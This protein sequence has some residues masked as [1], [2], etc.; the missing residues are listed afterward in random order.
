MI[1]LIKCYLHLSNPPLT[2]FNK[3]ILK[4]NEIVLQTILGGG[5][6]GTLTLF[7]EKESRKIQIFYG[8]LLLE[9]FQPIN[10]TN[11]I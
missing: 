10:W 11:Q 6:K 9:M 7:R 1:H 8:A 3:D 4:M 2:R 5:K